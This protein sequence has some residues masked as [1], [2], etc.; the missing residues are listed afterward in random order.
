MQTFSKFLPDIP[1]FFLLLLFLFYFTF[2]SSIFS[3]SG[4]VF[5]GRKAMYW[6][7]QI[8][9]ELVCV[10]KSVH[11]LGKLSED[12]ESKNKIGGGS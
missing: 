5:S 6:L 11:R 4:N 9:E 1:R 3:D 10:G 8:A 12:P 2:N 7:L